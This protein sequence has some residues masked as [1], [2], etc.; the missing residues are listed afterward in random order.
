LYTLT[1]SVGV[2]VA[3]VSL[4]AALSAGA[5]L[6]AVSLDAPHPASELTTKLNI[7]TKV[8]ILFI[9]CFLLT[10]NFT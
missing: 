6:A 1:D 10:L 7:N 4:V 5:V 2:S 3:V 8:K 9:S